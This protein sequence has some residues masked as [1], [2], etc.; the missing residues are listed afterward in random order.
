M[1]EIPDSECQWGRSRALALQNVHTHQRYLTRQATQGRGGFNR[2][3]HSAEPGC[4]GCWLLVVDCWLLVVACCLLLVGCWLLVDGCWLLL[5]VVGCG[6]LV[7][8]CWL[9]VVGCRLLVVGCWLLSV[10]YEF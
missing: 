2:S 4:V 10:G 5:L 6:L 7:V 1:F 3:A 9:L 8:G